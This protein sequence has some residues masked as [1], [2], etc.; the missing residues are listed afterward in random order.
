MN[1]MSAYLPQDR[2]HALAC[3]APIPDHVDGAALFADI[4]GFTPLTEALRISLGPRQGSE[5]LSDQINTTYDALIAQVDAY[6]GSVIGFAGDAITCWFD[7]A[8]GPPAPRAAACAV[9]MQR[10]MA[11]FAQI[12]L[13]GGGRTS[14]AL[15]VAVACGPARRILVGDPAIQLSLIHI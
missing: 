8:D 7:A 11:A 15:K 3:G 4:S 10:A 13:P 14:L 5:A 12:V 1:P 9:G 6:R 2:R